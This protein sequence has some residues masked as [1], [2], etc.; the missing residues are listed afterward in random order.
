MS[1]KPIRPRTR[2]PNEAL[3]DATLTLPD[4]DGKY[5]RVVA[6]YNETPGDTS[7]NPDQEEVV[8]HVIQVANVRDTALD[9]TPTFN[10]PEISGNPFPAAR[11]AWKV[12]EFPR[13]SGSGK[14]MPTETDFRYRRR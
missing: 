7:T 14:S 4:G 13:C 5:Y 6:S 2:P 9:A 12:G 10:E 8:S 11:S 1:L 3:Q